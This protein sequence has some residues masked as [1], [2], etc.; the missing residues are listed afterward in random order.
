MSLF[1][2]VNKSD[3]TYLF[4]SI[5]RFLYDFGFFYKILSLLQ[6]ILQ[7]IELT[8]Q[9]RTIFF[10]NKYFL[11]FSCINT[12]IIYIMHIAINV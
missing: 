9:E 12:D 6:K 1:V 7:N 5:L 10:Q 3:G 2:M 11:K 4:F 8:I